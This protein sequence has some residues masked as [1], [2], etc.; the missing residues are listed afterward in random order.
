MEQFLAGTWDGEKDDAK[1]DAKCTTVLQ[2][3]KTEIEGKLS[4]LDNLEESD[5]VSALIMRWK[6][7]LEMLDRGLKK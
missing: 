4:E 5:Q 1:V 3:F 6:Q 7:I 2:Q